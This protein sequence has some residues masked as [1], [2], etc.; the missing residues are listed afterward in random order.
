MEAFRSGLSENGLRVRSCIVWDK[1]VHG[2]ADLQTCWAPR[3]ELILFAA[4][5]RHELRSPRPVDVI[6]QARLQPDELLHPY[7]KPASLLERLI[8]ASTD[9]GDTVA[10][11]YMGSGTTVVAAIRTGRRAVGIELEPTAPD[12]PDYFGIAVQ[13]C[14]D[15]LTRFPLFEPPK[16]KQLALLDTHV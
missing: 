11:W 9:N 5:G 7:Q 12:R 14:K 16:P 2:L 3:H 4:N 1:E 10:D 8:V 15:E 13:R 6:R